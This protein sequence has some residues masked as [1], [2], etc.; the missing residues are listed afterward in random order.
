M[1]SFNVNDQVNSYMHLEVTLTCVMVGNV[2]Y[3]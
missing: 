2:K 3:I 1:G